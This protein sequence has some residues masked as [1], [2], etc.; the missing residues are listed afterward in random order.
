[1]GDFVYLKLQPYAQKSVA[2]RANQKLSFRYYSPYLVLK[3]VGATAY[4][5]DLPEKSKIHLVVHVSQLKKAV[6]ANT[7]VHK[8]LP[9]ITEEPCYPVQILECREY[10]K[11]TAQANQVLIHWAGMA[12][13]FAT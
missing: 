3:K 9:L 4:K 13:E 12:E 11:G 7:P 8:E 5:L 6:K 2:T 10:T 1:M